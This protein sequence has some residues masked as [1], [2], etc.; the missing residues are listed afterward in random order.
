MSTRDKTRNKLLNSMRK[1]KEV[2]SDQPDNKQAHGDTYAPPSGKSA[3]NTRNTRTT[4]STTNKKKAASATTQTAPQL[5]SS[6]PAPASD[7][8]QSRGRIWPD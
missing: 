7:P 2:I 3:T 8:Y 1:T 6:R 5:P 4:S